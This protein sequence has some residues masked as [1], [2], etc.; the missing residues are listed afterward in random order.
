MRVLWFAIVWT[1]SCVLAL[2]FDALKILETLG[3]LEKSQVNDAAA[4][5]LATRQYQ[6]YN[7]VNVTGL[8]DFQTVENMKGRRCLFPDVVKR[9]SPIL[10]SIHPSEWKTYKNDYYTWKHGKKNYKTALTW[11]IYKY[12]SKVSKSDARRVMYRAF[13]LWSDVSPLTFSE[14]RQGEEADIMIGFHTGDHHKPCNKA[15]DGPGGALAHGS[16]PPVPLLHIDD[17][18][19]WIARG[20][21]LFLDLPVTHEIGHVLGL[22]HSE[23]ENAV[24]YWGMYGNEPQK[25][26]LGKDDI[27]GIQ[28]IYGRP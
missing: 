28:A 5:S 10:D 22:L 1:A 26:T 16:S 14:V 25:V 2:D 17:S 8:L 4:V 19:P 7:R 27:E 21:G 23:D 15:F 24:M 3:Y 9:R 20:E 12:S 18:E 6:L 11:S 13:R